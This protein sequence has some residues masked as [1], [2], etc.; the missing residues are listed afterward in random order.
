M[1]AAQ[2]Q[3]TLRARLEALQ[4][5]FTWDLDRSRSRLLILRDNLE[6]IGPV[7]GYPWLGHIY[8][9][10]AYVHYQL[11][12]QDAILG[13]ATGDA[14]R[15]VRRATEAFRQIR[16]TVSDEGPWLVVNYGNLAW[17][18]YHLGEPAECQ[19]YVARAEA[20]LNEYPSP[21]QGEPHPE[22]CAE[23]AWTL[24]K[25]GTD[26]K[27]K[28]I[29]YFQKATGMDPQTAW[30]TSCVLAECAVERDAPEQDEILK[31]LGMAKERD[32]ENVYLAV[33]YL[34]RLAETGRVIEDEARAVA[35]RVLKKP[36]SSYSGLRPL[37]RVYR[38]YLSND[39]AT[40]LAEEALGR[41]PNERYLKSCL[42]KCYKWS[43]YSH[44]DNPLM[45]SMTDRAIGL[46]EEVISL[47]P[48]SSLHR[49]IALA[50]IHAESANGMAHADRIYEEML[51]STLEPAE[52]QML[53][54]NYARY[55][56][57]RVKDSHKSITYHMK[58]AEITQPSNSRASSINILR[59]IK[60]RRMNRM[61]G[62]IEVFLANLQE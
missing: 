3:T 15:C 7:E 49:K 11:N 31:K 5:H 52:L 24:M 54:N 39:E 34:E 8:N 16:N 45:K 26:S 9:L 41:H 46:H 48:H 22:I 29:E 50:N 6:D 18:S 56:A 38:K 12:S 36:V 44:K 21:S 23:K 57:F 53:Y 2:S 17:L 27:R 1:S 42:A 47:Y 59:K 13:S 40:D 51:E 14:L 55:L 35:K 33:L 28:A 32:P 25:F 58:A 60:E 43:I 62:E 10:Q 30:H 19:S 20:L 61:C 37:L 4:C